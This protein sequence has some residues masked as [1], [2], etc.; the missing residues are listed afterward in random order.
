MMTS[1]G[2]R[3]DRGLRRMKMRP[4]FEVALIDPL[5]PIEDI[6]AST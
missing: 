2:A 6:M 4:W 5:E 1:M 3:S